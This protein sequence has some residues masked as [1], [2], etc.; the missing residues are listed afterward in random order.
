MKLVSF[1]VQGLSPLLTNNPAAMQKKENK[2][3]KTAAQRIP[4]AETEAERGAYRN[5]RGELCLPAV[6]FRS[7]ML[8]AAKGLKYGKMSAISVT[9]ASVFV[10]EDFCV[11]VD[12]E[13]RE[14]LKTYV[15][16]S[17]RAVV[18]RKDGIVRSRPRM[19][20]WAT[21]LVLEI[22][23]AFTPMENHTDVLNRAGRLIGVGDFRVERRGWF[24]RFHA[25][26][27]SVTGE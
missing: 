11:L 8:S 2:G 4:D 20:R 13:T 1:W 25:T 18:N 23:E 9:Q 22:D 17:R 3:A 16:D 6:S 15:I 27:E 5:E 26:V 14:P 10:A 19:N 12:P 24:G 21:Q 7:A